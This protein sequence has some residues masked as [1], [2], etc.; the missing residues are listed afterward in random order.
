MG[1]FTL[2]VCLRE[3]S[4]L[5]NLFQ[6]EFVTGALGFDFLGHIFHVALG[7]VESLFRD[8]FELGN[9]TGGF[10]AKSVTFAFCR[11]PQL[12]CLCGDGTSNRG[13]FFDRFGA[14]TLCFFGGFC[15]ES[16]CLCLS[17]LEGGGAGIREFFRRGDAL[18]SC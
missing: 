2:E 4:F 10:S 8:R 13:R 3:G 9:L 17:T 14:Q 16:L 5:L 7:F 18:E 15:H 6:R 1:D 12:S 11:G